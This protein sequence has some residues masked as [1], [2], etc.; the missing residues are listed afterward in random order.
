MKRSKFAPITAAVLIG[1]G[2][3]VTAKA[4]VMGSSVLLVHDAQIIWVDAPGGER[5]FLVD[6]SGQGGGDFSFLT[7]NNNANVSASLAS[8]PGAATDEEPAAGINPIDLN[9]V[10]QGTVPP[11]LA[12]NNFTGLTNPAS[13]QTA[14]EPSQT[15][16]LGDS[17]LVDITPPPPAGNPVA[18]GPDITA[19]PPTF[20]MADQLLSGAIVDVD[21]DGDGVADVTGGADASLRSDAAIAT[22]D[23]GDA[24]SNV[25]AG[26]TFELVL[27]QDAQIRFDALFSGNAE[28]WVSNDAAPISSAQ[29]SYSF[30]FDI[31]DETGNSILGGGWS[32]FVPQDINRN[33]GLPGFTT[34]DYYTGAVD[35]SP[36]ATLAANTRYL[37]SLRNTTQTD[38]TNQNPVPAPATLL[39]M[40]I[41]LLGIGQTAR[42]RRS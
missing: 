22:T 9:Q 41:G 34:R 35:S 4:D 8:V 29:A 40:A 23:S 13:P 16:P 33:T 31:V 7:G 6:A 10:S 14:T 27:D 25:G 15:N 17:T 37:I 12:P 32:P 36:T 42:R 21:L 39:L 30:I 2:V 26:F 20:A 38:V 11:V 1:L 18:G 28:V 5:T 24:T 19:P 3:T